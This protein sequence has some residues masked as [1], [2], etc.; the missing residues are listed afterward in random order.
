MFNDFK[1]RHTPCTVGGEPEAVVLSRE[2]KATT[3]IGKEYLYNGLFSP[4]SLVSQG[5]FVEADGALYLTQTMRLTTDRDKYC[6]L[7]KTNVTA[8]I[9]RYTQEYDS[10]DNPKGNPEFVQIQEAR[11]FAQFVSAQLRLDDP[12]L[13]PTTTYILILQ[14]TVDVR[15]PQDKSLQSPDRVLLNGRP[16]QVDAI[17]DIK[18]PNLLYVQLSED[19]R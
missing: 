10:N 6:S 4:N 3:I 18:Y 15:R 5:L 2:T 19:M 11:G 16:Y 9:Q 17:D 13:L 12:G 14:T 7:L 1:H 8:E